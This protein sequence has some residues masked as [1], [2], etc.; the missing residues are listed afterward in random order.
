MASIHNYFRALYICE[1]EGHG[2]GGIVYRCKHK[3]DGMTFAIKL[4]PLCDSCEKDIF[5]EV[6]AIFLI[7]PNILPCY[8]AWV[9]NGLPMFPSFQDDLKQMDLK[10]ANTPTRILYLLLEECEGNLESLSLRKEFVGPEI[11][12]IFQGCVNGL[13]YLHSKDLVH[14]DL[15]LKNIFMNAKGTAKIGDFGCVVEADGIPRPIGG[16]MK[17]LAPEI[18]KQLDDEKGLITKASDVYSLSVVILEL[19]YPAPPGS[20]ESEREHFLSNIKNSIF[21]EQTKVPRTVMDVRERM[22]NPDPLGRPSAQSISSNI[23]QILA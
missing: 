11:L 22:L 20:T 2:G 13:A 18:R 10:C 4:I 7:H 21:Q 5:P 19:I 6:R 16:V 9:E 3:N 14:G 1:S 17:Y 23:C 8:K 15:S 12:D